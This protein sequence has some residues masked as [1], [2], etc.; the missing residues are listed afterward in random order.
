MGG[1]L[2]APPDL[3][4]LAWPGMPG[5]ESL[6][7]AGS[8]LGKAIEIEVVSSNEELE[9]RLGGDP[10]FDLIFPSDYLVQRLAATEGLVEHTLPATALQRLAS[11]A[12][13]ADHDPGCVWSVPF[14]YGTTGYLCDVSAG[15]CGPSWRSLFDPAGCGRV[16]ML[17]EIREVAGAALIATG[18]DP[19][20]VTTEA[21]AAARDLLELQLPRVARYDSDDF[22]SPVVEGEVSTHHA[23]SGPASLAV[24]AHRRLRYV[25]PREGAIMWITAAAIPA[26]APEPEISQALIAELMDPVL[27]ARTT[28]LHGFATPNE[29]GRDLLPEGLR[30]DPALFGDDGTLARCYRL[31]D[32]GADEGRLAAVIPSDPRSGP[33]I[34][35]AQ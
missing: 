28:Q 5:D 32:L 33:V 34:K 6:A 2:V 29:A 7:E 22:V 8:R 1:D 20:D 16:G 31:S 35:R 23:W 19:N 15:R 14:A 3:R 9:G 26:E 24:R 12:L 17:A 18:H 30:D 10:P 25:V 21:L 27:A 13:E 11:W 4:V